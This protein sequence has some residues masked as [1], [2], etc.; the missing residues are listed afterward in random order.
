MGYL[1]TATGFLIDKHGGIYD[2]V[3]TVCKSVTIKKSGVVLF[4]QDI[5]DYIEENSIGYI[6]ELV[7]HVDLE[8]YDDVYLEDDN[9]VYKANPKF[10]IGTSTC[11]VMIFLSLKYDRD[12][13]DDDEDD[14]DDDELLELTAWKD[15]LVEEGR[16]KADIEF[17]ELENCC[18]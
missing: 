7:Q 12:D 1:D 5:L 3:L 16:V 14:Y 11:S 8:L 15:K 9:F 2:Y 18:S 4:G 13:D 6:D 10:W 17:C